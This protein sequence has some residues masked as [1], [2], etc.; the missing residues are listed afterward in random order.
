MSDTTKP[1][2]SAEKKALFSKEQL[3]ASEKYAGRR[4]L[5]NA[6]LGDDKSY[7]INEADAAIERYPKG[8][9]K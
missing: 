3:M 2:R 4:D 8:A 6:L 5:L 9:V 1:S 7:S